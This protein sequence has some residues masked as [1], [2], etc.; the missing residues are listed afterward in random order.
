MANCQLPSSLGVCIMYTLPSS[1][2]AGLTIM[3]F[4]IPKSAS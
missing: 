3:G 2:F 4:P 1:G